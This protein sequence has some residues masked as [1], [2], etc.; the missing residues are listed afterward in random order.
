MRE[1]YTAITAGLIYLHMNSDGETIS[2]F[3]DE[4]RI[5]TEFVGL[6]KQQKS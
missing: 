1:N 5:I 2:V 3:T 6:S 4:N